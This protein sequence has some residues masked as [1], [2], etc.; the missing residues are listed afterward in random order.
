MTEYPDFCI[1]VDGFNFVPDDGT[2]EIET[3]DGTVWMYRQFEHMQYNITVVHPALDAQSELELRQFYDDHK[4]EK[5]RFFNPRD[6][7]YYEVKMK[8]PPRITG[9]R[10]GLL[11]DI[12]M[13]FRGT[14]EV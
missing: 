2:D 10:G 13:E 7:K 9:M 11:A 5:V 1:A 8:S 4:H 14:E 3:E 6:S 12:R